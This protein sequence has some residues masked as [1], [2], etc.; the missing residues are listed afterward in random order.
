MA[1]YWV[2]FRAAAGHYESI[3]GD[4]PRGE[5]LDTTEE[6]IREELQLG[7]GYDLADFDRITITEVE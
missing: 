6:R 1:D 4:G 3:L 5:W 7:L 2:S